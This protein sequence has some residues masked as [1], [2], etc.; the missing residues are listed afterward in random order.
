M[1]MGSLQQTK[2]T[3]NPENSG[4][5]S[6]PGPKVLPFECCNV[7]IDDIILNSIV[8]GTNEEIFRKVKT[9]RTNI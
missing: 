3:E 1:Y 9:T 5:H 6:L 8:E 7:F 4:K 2:S